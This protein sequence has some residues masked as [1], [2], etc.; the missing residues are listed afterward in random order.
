MSLGLIVSGSQPS[1]DVMA[2][3]SDFD[4]RVK[5]LRGFTEQTTAPF[6]GLQ[7]TYQQLLS[8]LKQLMEILAQKGLDEKNSEICN[9]S[10]LWICLGC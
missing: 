7:P 1:V 6:T 9:R 4:T 5:R 8:T 2:P 3:T 10:M